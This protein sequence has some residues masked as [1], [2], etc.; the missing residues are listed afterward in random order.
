ME[1]KEQIAVMQAFAD[2]KEIECI[3]RRVASTGGWV[4]EPNPVWD[5]EGF[6]YRIKPAP[7]VKV[8]VKVK[9]KLYGV[10]SEH[11]VLFQVEAHR[12]VEFKRRV[13][14]QDIEV[15]VM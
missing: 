7:T 4:S 1:L 6:N 5:W 2:G 10:I 9:V 3:R 13:P 8:K 12:L 14:S 11:G 15:E